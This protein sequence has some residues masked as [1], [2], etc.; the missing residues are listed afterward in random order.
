MAVDTGLDGL[1]C[2]RST[3]V[4]SR[5]AAPAV[6]LIEARYLS[7]SGADLR[8]AGLGLHL[9]YARPTTTVSRG[10]LYQLLPIAIGSMVQRF[11][12]LTVVA[13][14]GLVSDVGSSRATR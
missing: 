13:R 12:Q 11:S 10:E 1:V 2:A 9:V 6:C 14:Q 7:T 5:M 8:C 4:D 3:G